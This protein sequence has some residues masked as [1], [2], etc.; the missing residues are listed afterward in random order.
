MGRREEACHRPCWPVDWAG[1]NCMLGR[2]VEDVMVM[3]APSD[4]GLRCLVSEDYI[5]SYR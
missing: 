3:I 5:Y 2:E 4:E 1:V